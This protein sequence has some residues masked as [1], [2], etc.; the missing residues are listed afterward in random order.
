MACRITLVFS[1][2]NS[3]FVLIS[4]LVGSRLFSFSS[5]SVVNFNSFI[6]PTNLYIPSPTGA[7][8]MLVMKLHVYCSV[9]P[10]QNFTT[11]KNQHHTVYTLC[12]QITYHYSISANIINYIFFLFFF[13]SRSQ[14]SSSFGCVTLQ[15]EYCVSLQWNTELLSVALASVHFIYYGNYSG[16]CGKKRFYQRTGWEGSLLF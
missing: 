10:M 9:R 13:S 7:F 8:I 5:C 11:R 12:I 14:V 6:V 3:F 2:S 15:F 4:F 1:P 16:W